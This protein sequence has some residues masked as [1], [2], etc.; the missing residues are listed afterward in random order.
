MSIITDT[1]A[2]KVSMKVQ[3][4][5]NT[6]FVSSYIESR[7]SNDSDYD[8][9]V[10]FGIQYWI[11]EYL[12]KPVTQDDIDEAEMIYQDSGFPFFKEG[13][14]II[15][16]EMDGF[17]PLRIEAVYEGTV[18]PLSNVLAQ[19]INTDPRFYWL[20]TWIETSLLRTI[21]YATTVATNSRTI[22][23]ELKKFY[24]KSG[25]IGGLDYKLHDFGSRGVSSKESGFGIGTSSA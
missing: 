9:S 3:Y 14:Q 20:T 17:L 12:M 2:Y 23:K 25:S 16:D 15:V 19:V 21:W 6:E 11:R 13:W 8:E 1:D 24:D 10:F 22:K 18:M 5:P 7:G 4:P